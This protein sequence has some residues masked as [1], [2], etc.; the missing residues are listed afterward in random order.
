MFFLFEVGGRAIKLVFKGAVKAARAGVS[1]AKALGR[2][3]VRLGAAAGKAIVRGVLTIGRFAVRLAHITAEIFPRS[4]KFVLRQGRMIFRGLEAAAAR[5]SR[6]L[7]DLVKRLKD[8]FGRFK[9][10]IAQVRGEWVDIYALYNPRFWVARLTRRVLRGDRGQKQLERAV[11]DIAKA[12]NKMDDATRAEVQRLAQDLRQ[13]LDDGN[14]TSK[15]RRTIEGDIEKLLKRFQGQHVKTNPILEEA[16][17]RA[18]KRVLPFTGG[19]SGLSNSYLNAVQI[20]LGGG[21]PDML[22]A[23]LALIGHLSHINAHSAVEVLAAG[24]GFGLPFTA[25]QTM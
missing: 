12:G 21:G 15:L 7:D 11:D 22:H 10:F 25:G 8:W 23:R 5:A 2:G 24:A 4:G 1:A 19:P 17:A 3:T 16:W 6:T 9:G 20:L 14:F 18:V 13:A